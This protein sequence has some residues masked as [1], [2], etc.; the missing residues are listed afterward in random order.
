L[1]KKVFLLNLRNV[2]L[3][4]GCSQFNEKPMLTVV[5]KISPC[6]SRTLYFER[7]IDQQQCLLKLRQSLKDPF[8]TKD[9][10]LEHYIDKQQ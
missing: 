6:I 10:I 2:Y 4:T 3:D 9:S 8:S 1:R 5:L 7:L